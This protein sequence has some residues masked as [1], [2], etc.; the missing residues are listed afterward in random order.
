M[1]KV[2]LLIFSTCLSACQPKIADQQLISQPSYSAT[3]SEDAQLA[4]I[5]TSNADLQLWDLNTKQQ[6]YHWVHGAENNSDAIDT[7]ISPNGRF[8]ASL[9]KQSVA[10]W[11]ISDGQSLGWWSLPA[12][13]QSVAI[14]N[15]GNLLVGL[16][17]ASVMS[18]DPQQNRLIQF[19][20][21]SEKINRVAISANGDIAISGAN[22]NQTIVWR[23][24]TGQPLQQW[25]LDSRVTQV[26]LNHDASLAFAGDSTNMAKVWQVSDGNLISELNIKRRTMNFST[27]R[28]TNDGQWLMTGTPAREVILWQV[29]NGKKIANWRVNRT[30]HAQIKGAV[31]YSVANMANQHL[32]SFS[33]NGLLETWAVP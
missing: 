19:L 10:L 2:Y 13:G 16:S 27:A 4:L 26:A 28:F 6:K 18:L 29:Q 33:S 22:D 14:S 11:Q 24:D 5:S 20:G 17:D 8:A 7:A 32:I 15:R 12:S 1:K 3:I 30:E 9:S 31:V 25:T 23:T 21:H